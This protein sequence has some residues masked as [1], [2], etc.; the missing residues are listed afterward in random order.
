M[1]LVFSRIDLRDLLPSI[2][3][4]TLI[5]HRTDDATRRVESGR[6]LADRIPRARLVELPGVDC[7]FDG[8]ESSRST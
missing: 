3:V 7:P 5:L 6:F 8:P 4:P 1:D 2:R